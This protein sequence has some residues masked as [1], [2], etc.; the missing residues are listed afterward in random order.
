MWTTGGSASLGVR[1]T[2]THSA[3]PNWREPVAHPLTTRASSN[4]GFRVINPLAP[5][6]GGNAPRAQPTFLE[7]LDDAPGS[8]PTPAGLSCPPSRLQGSRNH[9]RKSLSHL[10]P[11]GLPSKVV[12]PLSS[13]LFCFF[14]EHVYLDVSKQSAVS[15]DKS[16]RL[17]RT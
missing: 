17:V 4:L 7:I 16:Y 6:L 14:L 8:G 11:T 15:M 10:G 12:P 5:N 9:W 1:H 13:L 2:P 3:L